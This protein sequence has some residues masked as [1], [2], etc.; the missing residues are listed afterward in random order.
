MYMISKNYDEAVAQLDPL[1]GND[2]M[3]AESVGRLIREL[4]PD[5]ILDWTVRVTPEEVQVWIANGASPEGLKNL[6]DPTDE[7]LSLPAVYCSEV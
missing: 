4:A 2:H 3:Q 6:P 1:N 7:R 5:R